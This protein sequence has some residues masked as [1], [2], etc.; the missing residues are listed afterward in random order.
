MGTRRLVDRHQTIH[1]IFQG[2]QIPSASLRF[3]ARNT[4]PP[5]G[6][7]T[8]ECAQIA[9]LWMLP[10]I[11][12]H[13][14]AGSCFS[15]D[16][17]LRGQEPHRDIIRTVQFRRLCTAFTVRLVFALYCQERSGDYSQRNSLLFAHQSRDFCAVPDNA[18]SSW[19]EQS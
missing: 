19:R 6:K 4:L 7:G 12:L 3:P 15:N 16:W 5:R 8:T 18:S 2:N 13:L 11:P 14:R 1:K 17:S 9:P 10:W